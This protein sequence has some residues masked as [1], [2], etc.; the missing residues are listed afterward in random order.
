MGDKDAY[1][2]MKPVDRWVYF[3]GNSE[4]KRFLF[5]LIEHYLLNDSGIFNASTT[6]QVKAYLRGQKEAVQEWITESEPTYGLVNAANA[7]EFRKICGITDDND[8]SPEDAPDGT[9]QCPEC[10]GWGSL[11]DCGCSCKVRNMADDLGCPSKLRCP[12]C[13]CPV[14][15]G[16]GS[17]DADYV[18]DPTTEIDNAGDS[19]ISSDSPPTASIDHNDSGI[20]S[21]ADEN[22]Y[23]ERFSDEESEDNCP[24]RFS[25]DGGHS[26][27]RKLIAA[28][29]RRIAEDH[30]QPSEVLCVW[31]LALT[32]GM[33]V[34][35]LDRHATRAKRDAM[36]RSQRN[37]ESTA[38][39]LF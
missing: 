19:L 34:F 6:A 5:F 7:N 23:P 24:T 20:S 35:L 18:Y 11:R 15:D 12:T 26:R 9:K 37:W 17:V 30:I 28:Q 29:H 38:C 2:V 22:N 27:R 39:S 14:C 1:F 16:E 33:V 8:T 10:N 31:I 25:D 21:D 3:G 13:T 32:V 36:Q 4:S